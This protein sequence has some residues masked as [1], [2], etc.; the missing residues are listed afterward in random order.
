MSFDTSGLTSSESSVNTVVCHDGSTT[1]AAGSGGSV[2]CLGD[3]DSQVH[4]LTFI[5]PDIYPSVVIWYMFFIVCVALPICR[6]VGHKCLVKREY[7]G[8]LYVTKCAA[9]TH[10]GTYN[11]LM[12]PGPEQ[13]PLIADTF[14][15]IYR[16]YY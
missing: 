13:A 10:G 9:K 16:T 1:S 14:L 8:A 5:E 7:L 12:S 2:K 3:A 6:L 4:T 11:G 15:W